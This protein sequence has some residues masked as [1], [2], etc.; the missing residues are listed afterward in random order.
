MMI[1]YKGVAEEKE[2]GGILWKGKERNSNEL[3]EINV[4]Q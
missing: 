1:V 3:M 4:T 2:V